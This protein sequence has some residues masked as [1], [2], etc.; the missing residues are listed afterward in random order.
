MRG[1]SGTACTRHSHATGTG[2]CL[3]Y[4]AGGASSFP[5][6][7]KEASHRQGWLAAGAGRGSHLPPHRSGCSQGS[8]F[9]VK[10]RSVTP[11]SP[12]RPPRLWIP[13]PAPPSPASLLCQPGEAGVGRDTLCP[14]AIYI[15]REEEEEEDPFKPGTAL[16]WTHHPQSPAEVREKGAEGRAELITP[17]LCLFLLALPSPRGQGGPGGSGDGVGMLPGSSVPSGLLPGP[18]HAGDGSR[19]P[20]PLLWLGNLILVT[21]LHT[22]T[23]SHMQK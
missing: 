13:V 4:G 19:E 12:I 2:I 10:G 23:H 18:E 22:R 6:V 1:T 9:P 7:P 8:A 16:G 3:R 21:H 15:Q 14:T 11:P 5:A 17:S 20:R